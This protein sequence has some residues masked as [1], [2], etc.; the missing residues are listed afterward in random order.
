[1]NNKTARAALCCVLVACLLVAGCGARPGS[2]GTP[3]RTV[4]MFGEGDPA[5][6]AY[7]SLLEGYR[8][9]HPD[10]TLE[11]SSAVSTEEWKQG[12]TDSFLAP[13][14]TPDVLFYFTGADVRRMIL[15]NQLVS[16]EEIRE[17]YPDYGTAIRASTMEVMREFDGNHYAVPVKGFWE[18]L[19]CNKDLFD[20]YNIPLP[21]DWEALLNAV[22]LFSQQGIVPIAASLKEVPHYWIEHL[23]L[24]EGGAVEH[25]L[26]P[27][28]YVPQSWVKGIGWF[29]TLYGLSAF[30]ADTTTMSNAEASALFLEKKAA[31]IL[32]GSWFVQSITDPE[33]TIVLPMPVAPGG[34]MQQGDII[35]GYS[36]GFYITRQAWEDPVKRELAVAFVNHMTTVESIATICA[37]G[38]A[39]AMD[40]PRSGDNT[41]LQQSAALLQQNAQNV[42]MPIDSKLYKDAWQ[43]LCGA[44]PQV[45]TGA[46]TSQAVIRE[47]SQRNQW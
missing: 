45:A 47:L 14:T 27:K 25:R 12:V 21:T 44:V 33:H 13:E 35:S 42:C 38:G 40:I 26:N 6:Q 8:Q 20:R 5:A 43:Y 41:P 37:M 11:D 16:V 1:M 10:V 31:M 9:Q 4:S 34:R 23:I 46:V 28:D 30:P 2:A 7:Q 15:N 32:D 24:A 17:I 3:L 39:P 19:F 36:S 29:Q 18:G 22:E